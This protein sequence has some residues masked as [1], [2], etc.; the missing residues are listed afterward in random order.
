MSILNLTPDSFSDGG[1]HNPSNLHTL[2]STILSHIDSG[3]TIIDLGGQSSRPNAPDVTA[4]EELSRI[5]PAISILCSL[6][7]VQSGHVAISI[8]TYR[9]SVARSAIAAGAHIINDISFGTLD[10]LMLSTVAELGCPY[11]GMHMRGTPATM[12]KSP[13]ISYPKGLIPTIAAELAERVEAAQTAGVR[14]WKM[15]LDPGIGFAKTA[16]QNVEILRGFAAL[17]T[18]YP[19]LAG[20][21]WLLGSS[22]K[23]FIGR[24]TGV[25][26]AEERAFGTAATVAAAV[27]GG[28]DIVRVHDVEEMRQVVRV[29]EAI[30]R[31]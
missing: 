18:E 9:A 21:P 7:A 10:E 28:A 31:A 23:G 24:L 3:A 2:R 29:S 12:S 15:L 4:D 30:W 14:R 5:L 22:R 20:M 1:L 25:D 11:I 17:R 19:A 27:V 26:K 13:H 6:P 16:A 8:D